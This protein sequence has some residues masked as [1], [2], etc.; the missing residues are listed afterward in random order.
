MATD[1]DGSQDSDAVWR[2]DEP[3]SPCIKICMLHPS[4]KICIGCGRTGDEIAAWGRMTAEERRGVTGA[5]PER[6]KRLSAPENRPSRR[7]GGR[8]TRTAPE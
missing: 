3:D 6:L 4:E 7:R 8:R 2:R 1:G 5:L